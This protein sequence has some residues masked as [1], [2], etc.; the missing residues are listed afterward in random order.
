[1]VYVLDLQAP[2]TESDY[3][4]ITSFEIML[5]SGTWY[6]DTRH[7]CQLK[8]ENQFIE[9]SY[10]NSTAYC[11]N[12]T[13]ATKASAK[14]LK[15]VLNWNMF[16]RPDGDFVEL[17]W[18]FGI[19]FKSNLSVHRFQRLKTNHCPHQRTS[20][21]LPSQITAIIAAIIIAIFC[22]WLERK[23]HSMVQDFDSKSK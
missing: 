11:D 5:V 4:N 22:I 15:N 19:R 12:N 13:F 9:S 18:G 7:R 10:W 2:A 1:M 20:S 16:E 14:N 6:K 17:N 3:I 8:C 21:S 23:F